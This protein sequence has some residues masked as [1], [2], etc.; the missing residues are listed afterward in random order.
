MFEYAEV[1]SSNIQQLGYD[2]ETLTARVVFKNKAGEATATWDYVGVTA[3]VFREWIEADSP[4][5]FFQARIKGHYTGTKVASG[6][7]QG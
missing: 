6:A 5:R 7:A 2:Q 3:A 4:G 1:V